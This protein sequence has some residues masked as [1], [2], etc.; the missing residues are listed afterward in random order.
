M[1]RKLKDKDLGKGAI[2]GIATSTTTLVIYP[3]HIFYMFLF[4]ATTQFL[5]VCFER[6]VL[7]L[8]NTSS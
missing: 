4:N 3:K 7:I 2:G 1:G 6:Y 8:S 5:V